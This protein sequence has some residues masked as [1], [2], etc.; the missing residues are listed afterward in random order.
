MVVTAIPGGLG[1]PN[2]QIQNPLGRTHC[3]ACGCHLGRAQAPMNGPRAQAAQ[4]GPAAAPRPVQRGPLG[5]AAMHY[6]RVLAASIGWRSVDGIVVHVG[7]ATAIR[8]PMRWGRLVVKLALVTC[9][10]ILAGT[11]AV[12][13]A[14]VAATFGFLRASM[15]F[16][17]VAN[18]RVGFGQSVASQVVGFFIHS[19]LMSPPP[20]IPACDYRVRDWTGRLH[21]IRVEGYLHTGGIALGDDIAA[22]G[23][24]RHGA[25]VLRRGWNRHTRSRILVTV[26]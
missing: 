25:L 1:C 3:A 9:L 24:D 21:L 14:L 20:M 5:Q 4:G 11:M 16:S 2:C 7:P 15:P 8:F 22:E 19:K 26:K 10:I 17:R 13:V 18:H 6:W 12:A 23:F